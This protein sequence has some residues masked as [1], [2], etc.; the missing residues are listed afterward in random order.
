MPR[1]FEGA[2]DLTW[3][4]LGDAGAGFH[5]LLCRGLDHV[6]TG[7]ADAGWRSFE[8]PVPAVLAALVR[9]YCRDGR[10]AD[11][12]ANTGY[13]ALLAAAAEPTV[14]VDAFEPYP[15]V[16]ARLR[17]NIAINRSPRIAVHAEALGAEPCV[18]SLYVPTDSILVETSSSLNPTFNLGGVGMSVDVAVTT[19]DHVYPDGADAPGVLKIDVESFEPEVL[20]GGAALIERHHPLL[21]LEVLPHEDP[22]RLEARRARF[23]YVDVRLRPDAAVVATQVVPD[24]DAWNHLWCPPEELDD[25]LAIVA[26]L[27]LRVDGS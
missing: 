23:G 22:A 21:V 5:L 7:V 9:R 8:E 18:A 12:G 17:H 26:D 10:F 15:P 14:R 25:V 3:V 6:A 4:D 11:V 20:D 2:A 1:R 13:Y 24:H 16:I 19:L 27:G